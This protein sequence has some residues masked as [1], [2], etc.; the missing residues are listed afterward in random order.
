MWSVECRAEKEDESSTVCECLYI[1]NLM[2]LWRAESHGRET[3]GLQV[4]RGNIGFISNLQP[5]V[6]PSTLSSTSEHLRPRAR[7]PSTALSQFDLYLL[8]SLGAWSHNW[9]ICIIGGNNY[10]LIHSIF[11]HMTYNYRSHKHESVLEAS[12]TCE[13]D[14]YLLLLGMIFCITVSE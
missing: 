4:H 14:I 13:G 12:G 1:Y 10:Y 9:L 5:P 6:T 11:K 8:S 7:P 2:L 3:A